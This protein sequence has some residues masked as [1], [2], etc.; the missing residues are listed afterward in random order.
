MKFNRTYLTQLIQ[1][2]MANLGEDE[3]F[4]RASDVTQDEAK[5]VILNNTPVG[6][7]DTLDL[8]R[9]LVRLIEDPEASERDGYQ[10]IIDFF[11]NDEE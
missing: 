10:L 7:Q 11:N 2:E 9:G 1:E 3:G 8:T 4:E 5:E 6:T